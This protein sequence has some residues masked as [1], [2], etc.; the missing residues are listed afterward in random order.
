MF[1]GVIVDSLLQIDS[2]VKLIDSFTNKKGMT[3]HCY[4]IVFRSMER[5]LTDEEVNDLQVITVASFVI[6]PETT[7]TCL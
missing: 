6:N 1:L 4:R 3:S 7:F 2:Q 5:S